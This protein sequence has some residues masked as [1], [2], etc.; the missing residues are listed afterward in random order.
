MP[1]PKVRQRSKAANV[2]GITTPMRT[3]RNNNPLSFKERL[4][5]Y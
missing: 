3:E 1:Q 5:N 2:F 4:N